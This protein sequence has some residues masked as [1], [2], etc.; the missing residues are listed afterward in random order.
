MQQ[1]LLDVL[2]E[3]NTE[4][5][6][7]KKFNASLKEIEEKIVTQTTTNTNNDSKLEEVEGIWDEK[8]KLTSEEYQTKVKEAKDK[9]ESAQSDQLTAEEE[10]Y[11]EL[12][13]KAEALVNA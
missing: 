10:A 2:S 12:E 1:E 5:D 9:A 6:T 7:L 8:F 13:K 4:N 11:N 3:Q